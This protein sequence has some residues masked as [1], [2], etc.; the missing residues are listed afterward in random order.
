M[1]S[2]ITVQSV[3]E[4]GR[5]IRAVR[6]SSGVRQDDV[7]GTAGVSHVYL[8]DLERGKETSQIG[9]ALQVMSELGVRLQLEIPDEA[10]SRYKDETTLAAMKE[11]LNQIRKDPSAMDATELASLE[12][13]LRSYGK[14]SRS[15]R[16]GEDA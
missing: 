1:S 5:V 2:K 7:A 9:R 13:S 8:R 12:Q 6:K 4:I 15:R 16:K 11:K 10:L 3:E 14:R